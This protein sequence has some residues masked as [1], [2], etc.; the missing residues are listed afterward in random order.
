MCPPRN[1]SFKIIEGWQVS[2]GSRASFR[3]RFQV[4]S[5]LNTSYLIF[6]S[7]YKISS[8]ILELSK[9]CTLLLC[10]SCVPSSYSLQGLSHY[11]QQKGR[12][13]GP[14]RGHSQESH[15][16]TRW[17]QQ[18]HTP[19]SGKSEVYIPMFP[20]GNSGKGGESTY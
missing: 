14:R 8:N 4:L 3:T 18:C 5:S 9:K 11:N 19:M 17:H 2:S 1:N 10:H 6:F 15:T 16:C 7:T 20:I 12:G 13:E